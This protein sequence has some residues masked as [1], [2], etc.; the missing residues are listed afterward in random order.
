MDIKEYNYKSENDKQN[1]P[2]EFARLKV[3]YDLIEE[4]I[5]SNSE[6]SKKDSIT[7]LDIGCGDAFFLDT[8]SKMIPNI[9][10]YAIDTAFTD[11]SIKYFEEKYSNSSI[12]FYQNIDDANLDNIEADI[13]LLLDVIEHIE[14]DVAF[15]KYLKSKSFIKTNTNFIITIP[16]FQSL[17]CSHD[18]WLGH[19]R[20]YNT[21]MLRNHLQEAGYTTEKDGYFFFT[22]IFP[23]WLKVQKEKFI[24]P[25]LSEVSG[26]GDW[27]GGK[28]TTNLIAGFLFLDYSISKIKRKFGIK[29]PGLS[30]YSVCQKQ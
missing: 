7:V 18:H 25:D 14:D 24:K 23:R 13:V 5:L 22:L 21:K 2:W 16:A 1:H 6:L 20:R 11:E 26:I 27:Q 8:L 10:A 30:T 12:K 19:Y 4:N 29:L 3:V 28:F 17:F 9:K 15:L